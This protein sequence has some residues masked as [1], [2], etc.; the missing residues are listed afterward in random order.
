MRHP[1][2]EI[3]LIGQYLF[4]IVDSPMPMPSPIMVLPLI[5]QS[6][7]VFMLTLTVLETVYKITI[8]LSYRSSQYSFAV[9]FVLL[10]KIS[11]IYKLLLVGCPRHG[12]KNSVTIPELPSKTIPWA[13]FF[14]ISV[15]DV[16][17]ELPS[18]L[19]LNTFV[20][21]FLTFSLILPKRTLIVCAICKYVCSLP[22]CLSIY[23]APY[24]Q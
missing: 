20:E 15:E 17:F 11:F 7:S 1:I 12:S 10:I 18:V 19:K 6:I 3:P 14:S 13:V 16:V 2:N 21:S 23:K 22:V 4:W 8:I 9:K 24:I 5:E